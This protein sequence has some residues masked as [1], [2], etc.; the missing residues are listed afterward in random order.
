MITRSFNPLLIAEDSDEDF[1]VLELLMQQMK[2]Q[3][4][5]YRCTNGDKVLDFV[6]QDGECGSSVPLPSAILL[7]LNLPGTDGREVLEQL[8]G[9]RS[10]KDIPIVVFTTSSNPKD[11][12][13]C[14]QKGA[15]GYLIKPV[16][17][18]E[19]ERI[20]RAFVEYWLQVNISPR[21]DRRGD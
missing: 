16:D 8:K 3:N 10:F 14:Y 7:D 6:Y 2:V 9:D 21:D 5:I 12:K 4:P 20:V 19:L 1:E 15:N 13:F 11:I 17:L 18:D